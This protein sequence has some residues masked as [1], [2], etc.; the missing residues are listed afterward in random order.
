MKQPFIKTSQHN[1]DA[2]AISRAKLYNQFI[3]DALAT[4]KAIDAGADV[5]RSDDVH[6]WLEDLA[7]NGWAER[8]AP[9]KIIR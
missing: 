5:Y 4:D 3:K 2:T 1:H 9:A 7:R 6:R 8:P